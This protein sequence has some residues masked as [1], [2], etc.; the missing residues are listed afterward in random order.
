MGHDLSC[1]QRKLLEETVARQERNHAKASKKVEVYLNELNQR[2]RIFGCLETVQLNNV[3]VVIDISLFWVMTLDATV[4]AGVGFNFVY[5]F[6]VIIR[7]HSM[8]SLKLFFEDPRGRGP[9]LQ[10]KVSFV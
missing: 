9:T 1:S 2:F 10:N 7:I 4:W 5:C 6:L 3:A 8:Q